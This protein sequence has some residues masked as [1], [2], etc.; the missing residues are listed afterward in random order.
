MKFPCQKCGL[1][2]QNISN[3]ELMIEYDRGDGV[4]KFFD[5]NSNLCKIYSNRPIFCRVD[6]MYEKFFFKI[7][8]SKKEYY[9]ENLKVCEFLRKRRRK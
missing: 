5:E 3:N 9:K 1:C 2:C 4:C 7:Y 8:S 6:E